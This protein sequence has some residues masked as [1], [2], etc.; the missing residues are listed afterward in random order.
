VAKTKGR[1]SINPVKMCASDILNG[2]ML[3]IDP[4]SGKTGEAGWATFDRGRL[5]EWGSI[6]IP[7]NAVAFKRFKSLG[8]ILKTEFPEH[9]DALVIEHLKGRYAKLVLKQS[10]AVFAACLNWDNVGMLVPATWQAIAKRLG[11]H[12]KDDAIDSVYLGYAAIAFAEGYQVKWKIEAQEAFLE[13]LVEKYNW[14][15]SE[16]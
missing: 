8:E 7:Y 3:V 1:K 11:G 14:Q 15:R 9:Y 13:E 4:S 6:E 5:M 10:A 12:I 16:W 2:T